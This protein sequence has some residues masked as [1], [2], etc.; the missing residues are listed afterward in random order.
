MIVLRALAGSLLLA[1]VVAAPA[2]G[3]DSNTEAQP[4]V[5]VYDHAGGE[6]D[7]QARVEAIEAVVMQLP[8]V[9]RGVARE[10]LLAGSGVPQRYEIELDGEQITIGVDS[11]EAWPST[12]DGTPVEL[13]FEG[14][15]FTLRRTLVDGVIHAHA[16]QKTGSGTFL[17]T[18]SPDGRT[19]TVTSSMD[20]PLLPDSVEFVSTYR[21]R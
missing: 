16:Q 5:G 17:F 12:L 14:R 3:A 2:A 18:L 19:L 7:E 4:F 10:R 21:R 1:V 11:G 20:S 9:F 13:H 6:A 8:A 15:A